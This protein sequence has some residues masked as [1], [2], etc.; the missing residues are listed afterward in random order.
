MTAGAL[1]EASWISQLFLLFADTDIGIHIE[2]RWDRKKNQRGIFSRLQSYGQNCS[3]EPAETRQGSSFANEFS[4]PKGLPW[5]VSME[6]FRINNSRE[7]IRATDYCKS[8]RYRAG[9]RFTFVGRS[10][11]ICWIRTRWLPGLSDFHFASRSSCNLPSFGFIPV[12]ARSSR[13]AAAARLFQLKRSMFFRSR[14][15]KRAWLEGIPWTFSW[16]FRVRISDFLLS[17]GSYMRHCLKVGARYADNRVSTLAGLWWQSKREFLW[18]LG[19][20]FI[21]LF[22]ITCN[23]DRVSVVNIYKF[24][25]VV[26][27]HAIKVL[28][29]KITLV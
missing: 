20:H 10:Y 7:I 29:M 8:A 25:T 26:S 28:Y 27:N 23:F 6:Y 13:A 4:I 1:C 14:G 17:C 16:S 2:G 22:N 15:A 3:A 9:W 5:Y 24:I 11:Y 18:H 19:G 12:S 21:S